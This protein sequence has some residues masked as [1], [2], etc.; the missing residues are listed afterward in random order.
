MLIPLGDDNSLRRSKPAVTYALIAINI[1]I[2]IFERAGYIDPLSKYGVVPSEYFSNNLPY[3]N[4]IWT[5]FLH[6]SL[7]HLGFNMLFLY[8]FGDNVED[9]LG[10]IRYIFFY[11]LTGTCGTLLHIYLNP[12]SQ[13]TLIGASG[14]I[15]GVMGAYVFLLP[16][17]Q[18]KVFAVGCLFTV[19]AWIALSIWISM[20][21][22]FGFSH[23]EGATGSGVAHLSHIGGFVSGVLL[24]VLTRRKSGVKKI[25][26]S[27]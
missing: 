18:I 17:N 8:I 3:Q 16:N 22:Y 5:L 25:E 24:V 15:S 21:F 23:M 27:S 1:I 10:K 9:N 11:L 2:Y 26:E 14:A 19:R 12:E 13:A 20:Q 7:S 6:G 4:F